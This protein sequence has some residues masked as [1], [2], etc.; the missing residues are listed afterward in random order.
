MFQAKQ[1]EEKKPIPFAGIFVYFRLE[2]M[3]FGKE[4][5]KNEKTNKDLLFYKSVNI[6]PKKKLLKENIKKSNLQ[7]QFSIQK[8]NI[9]IFQTYRAC[10]L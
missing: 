7:D 10:G 3:F 4:F 9:F 2:K 5:T 6:K 8:S 1:K